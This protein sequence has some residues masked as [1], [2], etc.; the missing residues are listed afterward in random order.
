MQRDRTDEEI[1]GIALA[2][3]TEWPDVA[4]HDAVKEDVAVGADECPCDR[5][6]PGNGVAHEK[7]ALE[8][9][10]GPL[11]QNAQGKLANRAAR[12]DAKDCDTGRSEICVQDAME[13]ILSAHHVISG[14]TIG[15]DLS[16]TENGETEVTRDRRLDRCTRSEM[17][18]SNR[19]CSRS[20]GCTGSNENKLS[21]RERGRTWQRSD[22]L[23]SWKAG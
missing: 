17:I 23:N 19:H 5:R 14:L 6:R 3:R 16:K 22:E 9:R 4:V 20:A 8:G 11:S 10:C 21:R 18:R 15:N 7:I 13:R 1:A 2:K 12:N